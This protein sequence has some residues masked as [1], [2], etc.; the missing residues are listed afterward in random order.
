MSYKTFSTAQGTIVKAWVKDLPFE[1]AAK[2]QV[3]NIAD[4]PFVYKEVAVMPDVH[5][6]KGCTVG[7]VIPMINSIVPAAVGVDI[8]CGMRA[9]KTNIKAARGCSAIDEC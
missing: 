4:M 9:V 1:E 3:F 7:S 5:V 2:R 6:G 8:G